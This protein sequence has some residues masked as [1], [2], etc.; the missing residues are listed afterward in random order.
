MIWKRMNKQ[1]LGNEKLHDELNLLF[2]SECNEK[3]NKEHL[4]QWNELSLLYRI[5]EKEGW[6][7][8]ND[9]Y[10]YYIRVTNQDT[11]EFTILYPHIPYRTLLVYCLRVVL[12]Y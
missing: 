10:C 7:L 5:N 1:P 2:T 3:L 12:W 9:G 11:H 4:I 6:Y 8:S